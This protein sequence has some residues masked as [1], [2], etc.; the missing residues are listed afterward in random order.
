MKKVLVLA[1]AFLLTACGKPAAT[2]I[3]TPKSTPDP[4]LTSNEF[5]E[6]YKNMANR[7][8]AVMIDNDNKDAW[9]HSGLD[10]AY[11]IYEI[12]VEGGSTR[13][14]A[15]YNSK[16]EAAIGPVRSSRHY[17][18]DYALEHDAIYIHYGWSP[19]AQADIPALGINNIN[20][21]MGSDSGSF[22]RESKFQGDYHSAFTSIEKINETVNKKG[23]KTE[24]TK[25]P[26]KF[27]EKDMEINGEAAS[28]IRIPY[29][30]FYRVS[31]EYDSENA[32]YKRYMN[33]SAHT[34]K[35]GIDI[36]AK[37]V[38]VLEVPSSSLGD[39]SA[40]IELYNTGAGKGYYFT[41][42]KY[43]NIIW[44][45]SSRTGDTV[46]KDQSGN[47]IILNPGQT[48]V[49]MTPKNITTEIVG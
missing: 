35:D 24:K 34:M 3:P 13:F 20:G 46:Y 49:L 14:L 25:S 31:Y 16:S 6:G 37:N 30:S 32:V 8:L 7:P 4:E 26:L 1:L 45:K 5:Y 28:I 27:N 23:Y 19:K 41:M 29:A 43:I 40:R 17:F 2:E 9:P 48:W 18:L 44:E 11:L 39:G 15:L 21:V 36:T 33:G 42:G 47:E 38:I 22:W 10:K 12:S